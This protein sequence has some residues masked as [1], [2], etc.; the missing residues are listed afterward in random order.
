[1]TQMKTDGPYLYP[2][3][4]EGRKSANFVPQL[5][6]G[7]TFNSCSLKTSLQMEELKQ[8]CLTTSLNSNHKCQATYTSAL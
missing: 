6:D 8:S 4:S 1:M 7:A 3:H 2:Q 5:G